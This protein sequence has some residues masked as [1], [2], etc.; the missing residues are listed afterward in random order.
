MVHEHTVN[1][2][3]IREPKACFL[4]K[5]QTARGRVETVQTALSI[6]RQSLA[7]QNDGQAF[8]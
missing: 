1:A 3:Q 7:T 2:F 6:L 5:V 8:A 4:E